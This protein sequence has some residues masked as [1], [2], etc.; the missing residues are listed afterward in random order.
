MYTNF[1]KEAKEGFLPFHVATAL[2]E[3]SSC[4]K[5]KLRNR[6][7]VMLNKHIHAVQDQP[8]FRCQFPIMEY[9]SEDEYYD[10]DD[11]N[12]YKNGEQ[13]TFENA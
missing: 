3:T 4:D 10:K 6:S 5:C 9:Y 8:Q 11:F 12:Y 2:E 13:D 7:D 1:I